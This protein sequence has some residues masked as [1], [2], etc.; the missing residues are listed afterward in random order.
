[1]ATKAKKKQLG[2]N[3]KD[4]LGLS[5]VSLSKFPPAASVYGALAMMDG[6]RK[7]SAYNWRGNKVIASVYVDACKRHIDAWFDGEELSDDA[8][9]PHIGHA[10]ACLAI[11]ADAMETGNLHDDRPP[12]GAASRLYAKWKKEAK[13]KPKRKR[14]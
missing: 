3:P 1:M 8:G 9:V 10:I 6:A 2:I 13:P 12:P 4:A 14:K 7:Y 5:K 11:L